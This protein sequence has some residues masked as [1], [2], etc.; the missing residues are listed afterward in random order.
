MTTGNVDRSSF[1]SHPPSG[2]WIGVKW[3]RTW[4]GADR[5]KPKKSAPHPRYKYERWEPPGP[6]NG[7]KGRWVT[8]SIRDPA[9]G[10]ERKPKRAKDSPNAYSLDDTYMEDTLFSKQGYSGSMCGQST[11]VWP[12]MWY[13][14]HQS[15]SARNLLTANDQINLVNKLRDAMRGSDFNP[16]VFSAEA[17]QGFDMITDAAT[18][19]AKSFRYLRRGNFRG[20]AGVLVRNTPRDRGRHQ[21]PTPTSKDLGSRWL[22]LQYGWLPLLKD[23]EAGA[24]MLAH[25]LNTPFRQTYRA[26]VRRESSPA[27]RVI[28]ERLPAF[29][30]NA[31]VFRSVG[32]ATY[33]HR[34]SLI[35]YVTEKETIPK[36]TGLLDPE[37]VA[38]EL[39][40]Y[41]FVV[42]WFIPI[43]D[44]LSAR[45]FASGLKG[46]F[47]TSDKR[48]GVAHEPSLE[49]GGRKLDPLSSPMF[50]MVS[51]NRSVS[52]TLNVPMPRM[53]PLGKAA[54]FGHVLNAIG[55]VAVNFGRPQHAPRKG[56]TVFD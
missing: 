33:T 31:L 13:C 23:A 56:P 37:L 28:E 17:K 36:L 19:I 47:V 35:A 50:R 49:F 43:G 21:L 22:E 40:P 44:W 15:W 34:R 32:K 24:H 7:H 12:L 42:D 1:T 53:K 20:A 8:V 38:W 9:F 29:C 45:A 14:G 30:N 11:T 5:P 6:S 54:S 4:N 55:L 26:S 2:S 52:T 18:R 27:S 51:F 16:S 39:L 3:T 25:H 48:T 10:T 46:T 41:S